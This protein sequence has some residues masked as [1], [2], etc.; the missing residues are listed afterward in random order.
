M[1]TGRKTITSRCQKW[2]AEIR[3]NWLFILLC[4][5]LLETGHILSYRLWNPKV[6]LRENLHSG[7]LRTVTVLTTITSAIRPEYVM[8]RNHYAFRNTSLWLSTSTWLSPSARCPA[9]SYR[10]NCI[11]SGFIRLSF[12]NPFGFIFKTSV[13]PDIIRFTL[14]GMRNKFAGGILAIQSLCSFGELGKS[15]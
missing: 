6:E 3:G 8:N 12:T 10:F 1:K 13:I 7:W 15:W 4:K 2:G 5:P 9:N 14:F 11:L